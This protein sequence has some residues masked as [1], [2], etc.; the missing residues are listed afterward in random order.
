[1]H[2]ASELALSEGFGE[3][4]WWGVRAIGGYAALGLLLLVVGFYILDFVTPGHLAKIIRLERN[5]NAG[6]IAAAGTF[7]IGLIVAASILGSGG[8][9]IEGLI[10]TA[11][12]GAT[13]IVAQTVAVLVFDK[14]IGVDVRGVI[15][16]PKLAPAAVLLGAAHVAIGFITAAAVF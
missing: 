13:G 8:S 9:L 5:P 10:A 2:E 1:M 16:E 7:G 6:I 15:A 3:A 12:F 14:V 11:A 4:V